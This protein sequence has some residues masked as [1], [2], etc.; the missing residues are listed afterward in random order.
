MLFP[1]GGEETSG[2]A[3]ERENTH[4]MKCIW[5]FDLSEDGNCEDKGQRSQLKQYNKNRG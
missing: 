2:K 1:A 3:R 4:L 5:R